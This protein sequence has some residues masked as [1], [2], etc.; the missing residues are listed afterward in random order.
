MCGMSSVRQRHPNPNLSPSP[1]P[2]PNPNGTRQVDINAKL[3]D[4][5]KGRKETQEQSV[6]WGEQLQEARLKLQEALAADQLPPLLGHEELAAHTEDHAHI[7][8]TL[9]ETTL[10][11]MK[12]DMGAIEQWMEKDREYTSRVQVRPPCL[13]P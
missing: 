4:L 10:K 13:I 11:E 7:Q 6:H 2:N 9:L 1:N 12:P 3:E 8:V 5:E